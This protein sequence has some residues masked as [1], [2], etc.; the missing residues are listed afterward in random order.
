ME[1]CVSEGHIRV[2]AS[3]TIPNPNSASYNWKLEVEHDEE[4]DET[5]VGYFF[6]SNTTTG[7]SSSS[8]PTIDDYEA[9]M[10]TDQTLYITVE[11]LE[12]H[13]RFIVNGTNG[14]TCGE[15]NCESESTPSP[16]PPSPPGERH[17]LNVA[18]C[19]QTVFSESW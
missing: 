7:V 11:G 9:L 6:E 2:F 5:C 19:M 8:D 4:T 13:N 16:P 15:I 18:I 10:L 1:F 14:N 12:D 17:A 3:V